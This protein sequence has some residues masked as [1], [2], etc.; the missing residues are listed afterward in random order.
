M[1]RSEIEELDGFRDRLMV[2]KYSLDQELIEQPSLFYDIGAKHERAVAKQEEAQA[3]VSRIEAE[4]DQEV[5]DSA[6]DKTTETDIK[7][8]VALN[9]RV[10]VAQE[11][12]RNCREIASRWKVLREACQ[13]R[14]YILKELVGLYTSQYWAESSVNADRTRVRD[15]QASTGRAAMAAERTRRQIRRASTPD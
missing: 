7:K 13:Q 2:D 12:Y 6:P 10:Q 9:E 14:S 4:V 8:Q 11:E 3:E 5:R 15:Y 1:A